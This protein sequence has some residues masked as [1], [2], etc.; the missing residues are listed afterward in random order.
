MY[1]IT[2][3]LVCGLLLACPL[4]VHSQSLQVTNANTA[5]FTPQNLISNVFL[6]NGVEVTN[7]SYQGQPL[8]VGYFTDGQSV[9]G[10]ERG[11]LM[12]TGR[13]ET[14][15]GALNEWGSHETGNVFANNSLSPFP[16]TDPDL[17]PLVNSGLYDI[18]SYVITFVPTSDTLRFRYCFA[19]EEYPEFAC[20]AYNDIFGFFIQ[21]PNYPTPTNIA[22]IPG[23]NLPVSIN[24]IHPDNPQAGPP[25]PAKFAQFY[26]NNNNSTTQPTY[27]GFTRVFTAEAIVVPCQ[28]YTIK[29]IIS[30]VGDPNY[31]SGVFLEAK[32][33]GTGAL[34]TQL[35]T[36]SL[37][38]TITEGC[39]PGSLTFRLPAPA[40][41]DYSI[42]YTI[43]G[44]AIN[45]VDYE[46]IPDDLIIPAGE[47]ELVIPIV[48][49]EDGLAENGE[50]LAVDVRRDPCNRDTILIYLRENTILPPNQLLDTSLCIGAPSVT[51]NGTLPINLPPPPS[52]SNT[53]DYLIDPLNTTI[54]AP[55]NVFG[56]LPSTLQPG[57]IRSVCLNASHIWVAD[58]D[59]YLVS[60]GGQFLELMTDCGGPGMNL[61][62]TCFTPSATKPINQTVALD[63]PYSGDWEPEGPWSDLW[64]GGAYP[65]NGTWKLQIKDDQQGFVGTLHD[66]TITFE[67]L[68]EIS[69]QWSPADGLSCTDCPT[70][71]TS[72]DTSTLYKLMAIDSY[73]CML[74]DSVK[75]TVNPTLEA[76]QVDCGNYTSNSIT[77]NWSDVAG[78]SGYEI[79]I[80]GDGWIAPGSTNSHTVTN[81]TQGS[82]ITVEV[83]ATGNSGG[84]CPALIGTATCTNC[85]P[86]VVMANS[87]NARCNGSA[88]GT[89]QITTDGLH[90]PYSFNLNGQ[91]NASGSFSGLQA[92]MYMAT[93]TDAL[94]CTA[95]VSVT[96][97][98]PPVL[99]VGINSVNLNCFSGDNGSA[100][101]VPVGGTAP[102][103]Y[104][105]SDPAGQT[106]SKA[107][108][109]TAGTYTVT[110]TDQHNCTSTSSVT[111]TQPPDLLVFVTASPAKCF[112]DSTGSASVMT[113]GGVPPY[114]YTWNN[115]QSGPA[116]SNL[117]AGSYIVT[118][119][120]GAG[121]AKTSFA[122]IGQPTA[123]TATISS[124]PA[125]CALSAN[126]SLSVQA[127]GGTGMLSYLWSDPAGQKTK[128]ASGLTAGIYTVTITDQNGCTRTISDTVSAPSA[129]VL[130]VDAVNADCN[131][132]ATGSA[133]VTPIGG[134]GG[135]TFLWND[136]GG[137]STNLA[138]NLTAG[139]YTVT[140]TDSN[141]CTATS[142]A[143]VTE[144]GALDLLLNTQPVGCFGGTDGAVYSSPAGGTPP[145]MY[146][147]SSG[148]TSKD[149]TGVAAGTYM[150][151]ITDANGCSTAASATI[152]PATQINITG[153][154]SSIACF[155]ETNGAIVLEISGG[156]MPYQVN[157]SGPA[158]FAST[159]IALTNLDAGSYTATITDNSGCSQTMSYLVEQ[160][161]APLVADLPDIGDTIC[162]NASNGTATVA[163]Q[164]GMAPYVY[165][166]SIPGQQSATITGLKANL[167]YVTVTD[168]HNC[169]ATD[170]IFIP[171]R[172]QL[173]AWAEGGTVDCFG[174]TDGTAS[175]TVVFYGANAADL[176]LF[177]YK[178]STVP[179]QTGI[180]ATGLQAGQTYTVTVT[181][182]SGCS[183]TQTATIGDVPPVKASIADSAPP[184]CFGGMDGWIIAAGIG[185][186]AP[187]TYTWGSGVTTFTDSLAQNLPAGT[188]QVTATDAKGCSGQV[189]ITLSQPERITVSFRPEH[190]LCFGESN[191]TA[192]A[193]A[194]GG[195]PGY[196]FSWSSGSS[197]P[198]VENLAAGIYSVTAT[199]QNGCTRAESV[200]IKQPASP[201]GG[202]TDKTDIGCA[203]GFSGTIR[204]L[205]SGGT[206]PYQYALNS[207]N[208]NGSSVQIGLTAGTYSP[209][210]R[211]KNGCVAVLDPVDILE[212]DPVLVDLG[213]SITIQLG[214]STQLLATVSNAAL[215]VT[216][217]WN[218]ADST[219]L[220]CLDCPDPYV[221]GLQYGHW[222][223]LVVMD[224]LGC[225]A[226]ARV[227]VIVE[228]VRKVFV[229]T[230]FSPNGDGAN[231]LL[232]VHGQS[233][234]RVRTFQ[235]FDRWGELVFE[236][237][238]FPVNDPDAGWDGTFRGSPV[239]P[240]VY[241]WVLEVEFTDGASNIYRGN[242]TLIR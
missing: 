241:V 187:Y 10:L 1:K 237:G 21:G 38:G 93:V 171:Q 40:T 166:W 177:T 101:A 201:L 66:W 11:I 209:Q 165:N 20:T 172:A 150:L 168:D 15:N 7:I 170:S 31:D 95:T 239:N 133:T 13:S 25:C 39:S 34:R 46:T 6:G 70:P 107:V 78:A 143:T 68:Y 178:W 191:G 236:G 119:V 199:D 234:A 126:G 37:D 146:Q 128:Q 113:T 159:G 26:N 89:V 114:M 192:E 164:G 155:G 103:M 59:I 134:T 35:S 4:S 240:G 76:P 105:W 125:S 183:A 205:G 47:Q 208:W 151:T 214:A 149:L 129:M 130:T 179:V 102:Y 157:W 12:T 218:P 210:I 144:P 45:G 122:L 62:N 115:G 195:K 221:D 238:D 215:P 22:L 14:G 230:A 185:G 55:I 190:V 141:A 90:P 158:G 229:P 27:D 94:G 60:P 207:G 186:V 111:L 104:K 108:N 161:G 110:V 64:G 74:E 96:I 160:P 51:L 118:V 71:T 85:D 217:S 109:L 203:G 200:E 72:P 213:P 145:Y 36:P 82:T 92:G 98:E 139:T 75:V 86:P 106:S 79:S 44:P 87:T 153:T 138:V 226:N 67:P 121:C 137:Q 174:S 154:V 196:D 56:V 48:A 223:D 23:T 193:F 135:Y 140:V 58:F 54:S 198:K 222:F 5:P 24:N 61:T 136:S 176:S 43:L 50:F 97:N 167:Y 17:N 156:Q 147:W 116:A 194:S 232:L 28:E 73:G 41:E 220:S 202:T 163:V 49:L 188:Y 123:I 182:H 42:D 184:G 231:D 32:S 120:D 180:Q 63:A 65:T 84:N 211:D 197:G 233:S 29:L 206:P 99:N 83:Q 162:F 3:V 69:Y 81:L 9:I 112:G 227:E 80:N 148:E 57:M 181:D 88:D 132:A 16:G 18:C 117:A 19:S 53:Q 8:A 142:S 152:M 52:F 225:T 216:Y 242:T 169:T 219:W 224:A 212:R 175:V 173:F 127:Q 100:T 204:I 189:S 131:G 124:M 235:V 77:V 228:K 30:D 2:F 91:M 33:F